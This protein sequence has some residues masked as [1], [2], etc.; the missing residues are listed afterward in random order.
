MVAR[1]RER[2]H[3][4][5]P[6]ALKN[7]P[8]NMTTSPATHASCPVDAA[9][10]PFDL[11]PSAR[12][13]AE[14]LDVE[15]KA[16]QA[17]LALNRLYHRATTK[18]LYDESER[19]TLSVDQLRKQQERLMDVHCLA[20]HALAWKLLVFFAAHPEIE[21]FS[22]EP[23]RERD[24]GSISGFRAR[25]LEIC[26]A[27]RWREL[28]PQDDDAQKTVELFFDK[29]EGL[30]VRMGMQSRLRA[31]VGT[32]PCASSASQLMNDMRQ[33]M[34]P[35]AFA[36]WEAHALDSIVTQA[37]PARSSKTPTL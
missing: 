32:A 29:V 31:P 21:G 1:Q 28:G 35:D 4:K 3:E 9:L 5:Q 14:A 2:Y 37:L 30:G 25:T 24:G 15:R 26:E 22:Y 10:A 19:I 6:N 36:R 18:S 34:Q 7:S 27:G 8:L 23:Q 20:A 33:Q 11:P 17:C 16:D 12:T 13:L